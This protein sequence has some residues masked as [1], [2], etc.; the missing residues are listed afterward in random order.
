MQTAGTIVALVLGV[1]NLLWLA[2]PGVG[3][4]LGGERA[5]PRSGCSQVRDSESA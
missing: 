2:V 4:D 5:E 3:T 1:A